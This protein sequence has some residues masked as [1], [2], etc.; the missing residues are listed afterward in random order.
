M[1]EKKRLEAKKTRIIYSLPLPV[2]RK[3]ISLVSK[4]IEKKKKINKTTNWKKKI[5]VPNQNENFQ[6][7]KKRFPFY[8]WRRNEESKERRIGKKQRLP[9][10]IAS[11]TM[12]SVKAVGRVGGPSHRPIFSIQAAPRRAR[13][14][15]PPPLPPPSL[16]LAALVRKE[17]I[18]RIVR[19]IAGVSGRDVKLPG[20]WAA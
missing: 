18:F 11:R 7:K 4:I 16:P 14:S 9:R 2:A 1:R 3:W 19:R 13:A 17:D 6:G 20:G 10:V 12:S 8:D 5:F 15:T